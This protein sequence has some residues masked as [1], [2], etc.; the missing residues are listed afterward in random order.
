MKEKEE[1]IASIPGCNMALGSSCPV[2]T[3]V[4]FI[5]RQHSSIAI[6]LW[7][8]E[9]QQEFESPVRHCCRG[10]FRSVELHSIQ[11]GSQSFC[12]AV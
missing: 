10:T 3:S 4:I 2:W 1:S 7:R 12:K 6:L 5:C 11:W 8:P 9:M